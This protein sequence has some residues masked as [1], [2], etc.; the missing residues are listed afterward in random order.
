MLAF[1]RPPFFSDATLGLVRR[2]L[3]DVLRSVMNRVR[4]AIEQLGYIL[5]PAMPELLRLHRRIPPTILLGQRAVQLHHVPLYR[6]CI[7]HH[8][9]AL[10]LDLNTSS[11]SIMPQNQVKLFRVESYLRDVWM[12]IRCRHQ[13]LK[14][15][16]CNVV[17]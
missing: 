16:I 2:Q 4:I 13:F 12:A 10:Q 5:H 1:F 8:R 14:V 11:Q 15:E 17:G 9:P 7:T 3:L 6:G